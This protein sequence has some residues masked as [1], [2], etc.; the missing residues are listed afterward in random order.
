MIKRLIPLIAFLLG[1][2][3]WSWNPAST[4]L[5]RVPQKASTDNVWQWLET[6]VLPET[7][8]PIPARAYQAVLLNPT[9]MQATLA[10][11]PTEFSKAQPTEL[12]LPMPDGTFSRFSVW[13]SPIMEP[14]LAAKYPQFQTYVV[15]GID[16]PTAYGRIDTTHKGFHGLLWTQAGLVYIDP[17][18]QQDAIHHI[19]YYKHDV[20]RS[21]TGLYWEDQVLGDPSQIA[22]LVEEYRAINGNLASGDELRSYR[23]AVGATG[24]YTAFHGGTV[25]DGLAAIVTAINRVTGLYE[26]DVAVRLILVANNDAVIY[27]DGA[28][29]PYTNN[30]GVAMLGQN[31]TNLDAVIGNAN[32]DVGHVFSTGGGGVASLGVPCVS[33]SKAR[34]VTGLGSPIGDPFYV[35]YVAHELGHQ[36]AGNHTFNGDS[37]ACFGGQRNASTAFEPGSA[38]TIMGYAGICGG[39][40][41]QNNSDA[42]FHAGSIE[43][44]RAYTVVGS[45]NSCAQIIN[46][47]N[48]IPVADAGPDY[49]I[50][51]NTPFT[52]V[53][54]ATDADAGDVL[55]Y[56]WEEMD[57]GPTGDPDNPS[58]DAPIFRSFL[59]TTSPERTFPQLSD[60]VNNTQ[61]L[62]EILPTYG[63]DLDFRFMVR[64]NNVAPSAGGVN[65][66]SVKLT[67]D[68]NSGPFR[69]TVPNTAVTWQTGD[70]AGVVWDVAGTDTSPVSCANVDILL[71][72][73]GGYTYPITL[74]ASTA[75]DGSHNLTV[76]AGSETSEARIKVAC[77][78]NIFFDIS[79]TDFT[80]ETGIPVAS[81]NVSLSASSTTI[82]PNEMVTYTLD[83]TNMGNIT[84]TS[85]I[86]DMLPSPDLQNVMC[87]GQTG[88]LQVTTAIAPFS[89]VS[90]QCI[91]DR[92]ETLNL[93]LTSVYESGTLS[94]TITNPDAT[95][96]FTVTELMVS[97]TG[98]AAVPMTVLAPMQSYVYT[99][100]GLTPTENSISST[101]SA[102]WS[103]VNTAYASAP[104]DPSGEQA[105]S[106]AVNMVVYAQSTV[107]L[108]SVEY[109]YFLPLIQSPE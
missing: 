49:T 93:N 71:S 34:G 20:N 99:C 60:I 41:I 57:L 39:D 98:C 51:V 11:A 1:V 46:T 72:Q 26:R 103:V 24:E 31:Q 80:I 59:P 5:T 105:D 95:R 40:D 22:E 58:A 43:E 36:F 70:T 92:N 47:G 101:V 4:A 96:T 108:S 67:V 42:M 13:N 19:S 81:L 25:A 102:Y 77:S 18:S 106:L 16:D 3:V 38:T 61:T 54:S 14:E 55:T 76:P 86:T 50:P 7:N 35:D 79:D 27:T 2:I 75:N 73:D 53:G 94:V 37:G 28:T 45:G 63:R 30:N 88:D 78:D 97:E 10:T 32:Y 91:A 6:A 64:D 12:M 83:V 17:L 44:I 9:A 69:V 65:Y 23:L 33:G 29:D 82:E 21:A 109:L 107:S 68:A 15:Q 100:A 62:G 85:T 84:A 89:G 56:A 48:N 87:N 104:E 90:Y 52:L 74:V 66:D 8:T